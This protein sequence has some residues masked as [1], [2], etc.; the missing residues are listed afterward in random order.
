MTVY[1]GAGVLSEP[2]LGWQRQAVAV[3]PSIF[4][5]ERGESVVLGR[6]FGPRPVSV[7]VR[8]AL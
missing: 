4:D 5:R 6:P 3:P 8:A 2:F 7:S 1:A